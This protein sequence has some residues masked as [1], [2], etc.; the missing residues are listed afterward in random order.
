MIDFL[1]SVTQFFH[2]AIV[3]IAWIAAPF[4]LIWLGYILI[5]VIWKDAHLLSPAPRKEE[6][7]VK[8]NAQPKVNTEVIDAYFH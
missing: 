2:M 4:F 7:D 8:T 1:I 5:K 6:T 3:V